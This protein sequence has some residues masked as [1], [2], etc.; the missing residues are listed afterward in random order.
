MGLPATATS[1][2]NLNVCGDVG[3]GTTSIFSPGMV[4]DPYG[5]TG[6]GPMPGGYPD[7]GYPGGYPDG[8]YPGG[9]YPDGSYPDGGSYPQPAPGGNFDPY[10]YGGAP[11]PGTSSIQND[12]YSYGGDT[13]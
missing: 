8:S 13:P 11:G 1:C 9:G 4:V 6:N 3:A 7:G 12:P 10:N 5:Y 2:V